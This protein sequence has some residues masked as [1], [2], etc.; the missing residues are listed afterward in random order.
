M[1][2]LAALS[3]NTRMVTRIISFNLAKYDI[4]VN[5]ENSISYPRFRND[6]EVLRLVLSTVPS[7]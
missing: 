7:V 1:Q 2:A 6:Y 5:F 4:N 3:Q